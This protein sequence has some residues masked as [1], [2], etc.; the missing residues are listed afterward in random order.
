M[1]NI[2]FK[3]IVAS[4]VLLT[5]FSCEELDQANPNQ[6]DSGNFFITEEGLFQGLVGAYDQLQSGYYDDALRTFSFVM[7]DEAT[8]EWPYEL[9]EL[10]TFSLTDFNIGQGI[11]GASYQLIS[12][13]Y[14]VIE[15]GAE[16]SGPEVPRIVAEAKF[17]VALAYYN[18]IGYFGERVAYVDRLQA[19]SDKQR[20]A[21]PGELWILAE[22]LLTEAIDELP[23][24]SGVSS[25]QYGRITRGAA[26]T[27]LA[28]IHLQQGEYAE[29][30]P[31]LAA[32]I[33]SGQYSLNEN[34]E[35]NFV[36][37]NNVNPESVF[38]VNFLHNG[39]ASET[40][41][42]RYFRLNSVAENLGVFGD[43]QVTNFVVNSFL[44]E[45]D[46]DGNQDPRMD[47]SVFWAG[48]S[49]LYYG[50][51][52]S[53]W[54]NENEVG[55]PDITNSIYKYTEQ[56]VVANNAT[57][58]VVVD[59]INGGTDFIVF[60]YAD[61]LLLYSEV[62]NALGRDGEK[63]THVDLVRQRSNMAP[64]SVAR[65]GLNQADFL[66]QIKHERIV[67]LVG[68]GVRHYDL[69][70]WGDYNETSAANDPNFATFTRDQDEVWPIPQSELDVNPLLVQNPGY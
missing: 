44:S 27:L 41:N 65:P 69:I 10:C 25:G 26:Q 43:I 46:A 11:W 3:S 61:V 49:R 20:P 60:R 21:E 64:L 19:A 12:R 15:A 32:V 30:E 14:R 16:V 38:Q 35:D 23:L 33:S 54:V 8:Q 31:L 47:A 37:L 45:N 40:D 28:K 62:L 2:K 55:N 34:F 52:H 42:T 39:V 66:A 63:Y 6:P 17:F 9:R 7:S 18:L 57:P 13:S 51:T 50:Q 22:S 59:G 48:S 36:E 70:R 24:A 67:E 53:W 4:L 68:E 56:D 5:A 1:K 29:A 58:N